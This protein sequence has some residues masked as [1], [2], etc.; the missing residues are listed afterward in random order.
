MILNDSFFRNSSHFSIDSS[1]SLPDEN[2]QADVSDFE[3]SFE[4]ENEV[5]IEL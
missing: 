5:V 1:S 3:Q 4:E 2:F